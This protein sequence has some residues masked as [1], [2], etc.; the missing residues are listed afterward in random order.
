MYDP[1]KQGCVMGSWS[2]QP[3]GVGSSRSI[4]ALPGCI[5][6]GCGTV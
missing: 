6:R 1:P 2:A 3:W 4:R 5:N